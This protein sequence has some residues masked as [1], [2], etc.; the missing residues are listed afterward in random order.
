MK[1]QDFFCESMYHRAAGSVAQDEGR[2]TERRDPMQ[3]WYCDQ[4]TLPRRLAALLALALTIIWLAGCAESESRQPSR[5]APSGKE[6]GGSG[7]LGGLYPSMSEGKEGQALLVYRNPKFE[8]KAAFAQYKKILLDPVQL[9]AGPDSKLPEVPEEQRTTIAKA[10]YAQ[11]YDKLKGDYQMVTQA[12]PNT[13]RIQGA[14]VDARE[15]GGKLEAVSYIPVP[16]GVP[17]ATL[18]LIKLKEKATG[19]PPFVGEVTGEVKYTD[20]Q[21]GEVVAALVDRRVGER[22][23]PVVGIF[24]KSTYNTW[25]DV[26][27]AIRYWAERLRFDLCQRR[28]GTNCVE[29]KE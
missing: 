13:L 28:G 20:A 14:I 18:I 6:V 22:S 2:I 8:D 11:L 4:K 19:K 26:D 10:A 1:W 7:F 24:S 17:G 23:Y 5:S 29:P 21:T 12:E 25:N 3:P 9:Y 16:V 27:E 15:S